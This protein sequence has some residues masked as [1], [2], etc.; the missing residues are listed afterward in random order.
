MN[1]EPHRLLDQVLAGEPPSRT[2]ALAILEA[3][4]AELTAYLAGAH[5]LKELAFGNRVRLCS[6]INAK[7][8]RCPENCSFCAQSAHHKTD[9]P[10]FPL[11]ETDAMVA[12]AHKAAAEG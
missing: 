5:Q 12:A 2:Q 3:R 11:I 9:A 10:V 4:G 7:S 8:G 6:I 1:M